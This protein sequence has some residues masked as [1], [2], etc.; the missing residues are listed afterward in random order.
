MS[1]EKLSRGLTF[2]GYSSIFGSV[3]LVI[4]IILILTNRF[5]FGMITF[6][7]VFV[8]VGLVLFMSIRGVLI[9]FDK[10]IVKPYFDIIIF[11]IGEWESVEQYDKIV[12]RYTN[13]SQT[14]NSRGNSTN[15]ITKS[16]DIFLTSNNKN[17][18]QIKEFINYM[19]AKTFLIEYSKRLKLTSLDLYEQMKQEIEERKQYVR[20]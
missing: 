10:M 19:D 5:S 18:L 6:G 12:L 8:I 4:G 20:R 17:E 3:I 15:Y 1:V 9:D 11:K 2:K 14:L 7:L 16:F 13:E